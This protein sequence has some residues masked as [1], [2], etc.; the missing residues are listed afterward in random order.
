MSVWLWDV[1]AAAGPSAVAARTLALALS[2]KLHGWGRRAVA[3]GVDDDGADTMVLRE[4]RRLL[5]WAADE[6]FP[7]S[8]EA[9]FR[10]S[11]ILDV[12]A[13]TCGVGRGG[14]GVRRAADEARCFS[15]SLFPLL[16]LSLSLSLSFLS[17]SARTG[18][19][20]PATTK[21]GWPTRPFHAGARGIF[22]CVFCFDKD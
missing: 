9:C 15:V 6:R 11:L 17:L 16:S 18:V 2:A 10:R 22:G 4:R 5:L 21:L 8:G 19:W 13:E 3:A 12:T 14:T 20:L 1:T 7:L